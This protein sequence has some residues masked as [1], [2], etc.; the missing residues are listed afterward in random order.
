MQKGRVYFLGRYNWYISGTLGIVKSITYA[1]QLI[2]TSIIHLEK[3]Y[4]SVMISVRP[5][6]LLGIAKTTTL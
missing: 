4:E 3:K 5:A 2:I 6:S 1:R